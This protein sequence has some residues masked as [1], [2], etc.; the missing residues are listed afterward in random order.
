M[1]RKDWTIIGAGPAGIAALGTL[2]DHGIDPEKI[3]WIDPFFTVGDFGTLWRNVPSNTKAKLFLSFLHA[4]RSFHFK[5][6][7][8]KFA[9]AKVDPEQSCTLH[10]MAEPLQFLTDQLKKSV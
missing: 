2:L 10:L 5:D 7:Q 1:N 8:T 6:H 4:C 9:L 3:A